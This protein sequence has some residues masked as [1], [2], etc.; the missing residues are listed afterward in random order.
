MQ[1][2]SGK[3]FLDATLSWLERVSILIAT[4]CALMICVFWA[5]LLIDHLEISRFTEPHKAASQL[6]R[7]FQHLFIATVQITVEA[8]SK[9]SSSGTDERK[10][11]LKVA[12]K[13]MNQW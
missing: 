4:S 7:Y 9:L 12:G 11:L 13:R 3:V 10:R 2:T 8:A 1:I 5:S 6:C